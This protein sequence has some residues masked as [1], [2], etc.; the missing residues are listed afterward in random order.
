LAT[1]SVAI[2]LPVFNGQRFVGRA[3]RSI[4]EQQRGDFEL[5]IGDD[6]ST[7]Q[8][9]QI[10]RQFKDARVRYFQRSSNL[11]L[12]PNLNEL[13]RSV[14]APLVRFLCQ[15]DQLVPECLESEVRL[16]HRYPDVGMSFCKTIIID[17]NEEVLTRCAVEDMPEWLSCSLATQLLFYFGCIPGNLSTVMVRR[18]CV[19]EVCGFDETFRV[20]G[21]YEMWSRLCGRWPMG[22][23]HERLVRMRSHAG[24]LSRASSSAPLFI[25]EVRRIR[26]SLVPRLPDSIRRTA[27]A[28][29]L[30]YHNIL[31]THYFLRCL[32]R[33]QIAKCVRVGRTL[34]SK[35]L[36]A[37][38]L[39][40]CLTGRNRWYRPVPKFF[41]GNESSPA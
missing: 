5:L 33:L 12:F 41:Y 21:D 13:L 40:W 29:R 3:I 27:A 1:P 24:Q 34:G 25:E 35:D 23:V 4:L 10:I 8:S 14:Q 2:L 36:L 30:L 37:G 38:I 19:Q 15:D 11:G 26:S 22:V 9:P 18:C 32:G 39:L 6:A 7:D 17:E 31:D 16:F 28:Y 20:A